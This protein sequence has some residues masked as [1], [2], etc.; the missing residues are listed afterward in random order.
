VPRIAARDPELVSPKAA[1][2]P[3]APRTVKNGRFF[4]ENHGKYMGNLL[5]TLHQ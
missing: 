1:G 4:W 3:A 5:A 2:H